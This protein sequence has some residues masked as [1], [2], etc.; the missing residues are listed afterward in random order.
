MRF[1]RLLHAFLRLLH[2]RHAKPRVVVRLSYNC[3]DGRSEPLLGAL[4][5]LLVF[6]LLAN[7]WRSPFCVLSVIAVL[8]VGVMLN[9]W[10]A[11]LPFVASEPHSSNTSPR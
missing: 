6:P 4:V 5:W 7:R 11:A 8:A 1:C 3:H 9:V 10:L 2:P